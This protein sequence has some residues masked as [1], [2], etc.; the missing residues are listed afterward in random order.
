MVKTLNKAKE[1]PQQNTRTHK[2]PTKI[3]APRKHRWLEEL[4]NSLCK[5]AWYLPPTFPKLTRSHPPCFEKLHL[6]H[7]LR[8]SFGYCRE[9][10]VIGMMQT[11]SKCSDTEGVWVLGIWILEVLLYTKNPGY[12]FLDYTNL[13]CRTMK[14]WELF[15]SV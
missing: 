8:I 11:R 2:K 7:F 5:V 14:F 1:R 6:L 13:G 3:A 9:K 12:V 15:I 10:T 4:S